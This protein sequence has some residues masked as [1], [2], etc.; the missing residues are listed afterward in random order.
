M[1][2]VFT[3]C[4]LGC[5]LLLW[6]HVYILSYIITNL[7]LESYLRY[8]CGLVSDYLPE[9]LS[10][11]LESH[12]KLPPTEAEKKRKNPMNGTPLN[13]ENHRIKKKKVDDDDDSPLSSSPATPKE[14]VRSENE[15]YHP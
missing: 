6:N 4:T 12:L 9:S 2:I 3:F 13:G 5:I 1:K 8:A 14:K 15:E 10:S 7:F 11:A